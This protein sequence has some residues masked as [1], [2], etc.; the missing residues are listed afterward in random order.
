MVNVGD[1]LK[2]TSKGQL[3]YSRDLDDKSVKVNYVKRS[4]DYSNCKLHVKSTFK[5]HLNYNIKI[6]QNKTEDATFFI[7]TF[8][9]SVFLLFCVQRFKCNED[10]VKIFSRYFNQRHSGA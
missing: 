5:H 8:R 3:L 6:S 9:V 4:S 10:R 7:N 2:K 1:Q